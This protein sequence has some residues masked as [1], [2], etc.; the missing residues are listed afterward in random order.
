MR[1]TLVSIDSEKVTLAQRRVRL[2]VVRSPSFVQRGRRRWIGQCEARVVA[3]VAVAVGVGVEA[4]GVRGTG[5]VGG[6]RVVGTPPLGG[7]C[8]GHGGGQPGASTEGGVALG[9]H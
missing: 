5:N 1:L 3:V 4:V 2:R 9:G 6:C 7:G 8:G